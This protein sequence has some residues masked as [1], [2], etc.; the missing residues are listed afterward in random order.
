MHKSSSTKGYGVLPGPPTRVKARLISSQFA[1][2]EWNVPKILSETV[3]GYNVHVR[4]MNSNEAFTVIEK[5]HMP[6]VIEDLESNKFYEIYI[7]AVNAHGRGPPSSRLV[8]KTKPRVNCRI[9]INSVFI[10]NYKVKI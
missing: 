10:L 2:I 6:I 4:K 1:V 3:T 7:V 9:Q 8:F 5:D